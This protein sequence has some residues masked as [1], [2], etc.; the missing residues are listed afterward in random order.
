MCLPL[1]WEYDLCHIF[2]I[3]LDM[4]GNLSH[5]DAENHRM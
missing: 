4:Q 5:G 3:K 1:L 2:D